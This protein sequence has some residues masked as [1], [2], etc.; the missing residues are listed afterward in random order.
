M[1]KY[2]I[3]I[4]KPLP[5]KQTIQ[6]YQDFDAL[7]DYYKVNTKYEFWK[8]LYRNPLNFAVL[9]LVVAVGALIFDSVA[10]ES[11]R[12]LFLKAP[13]KGLL[14]PSESTKLST[15]EAQEL[16]I[17]ENIKVHL[18]QEAFENQHGE[19]VRGTISFYYRWL[20]KAMNWLKRGL[21]MENNEQ[22]LAS[23][24]ILELFAMQ[25]DQVLHLRKGKNI[26]VI[27]TLA[28]SLIS[29]HPR[30]L[31]TLKRDWI[32]LTDTS[33][34]TIWDSSALAQLEKPVYLAPDADINELVAKGSANPKLQ[35]P[36]QPFGVK[37]S[38]AADY[39]HF[40]PYDKVYWEYQD[41]PGST[42]PWEEQLLGPENG[43]ND[44]R[45]RRIGQNQYQ[46]TFTKISSQNQMIRKKVIAVPLFEAKSKAEA[47]R[48]YQAKLAA[49]ERAIQELEAQKQQ[50]ITQAQS[51]YKD[52]LEVYQQAFQNSLKFTH[53]ECTVALTELGFV[54]L[55]KPLKLEAES[56]QK[57]PKASRQWWMGTDQET[58]LEMSKPGFSGKIPA[59]LHGDV[60]SLI[61]GE[62]QIN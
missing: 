38:N 62:L 22:A 60:V 28:D 1:S 41:V 31:D 48:I 53:H 8:N 13:S 26:Q 46:L 3:H 29:Y 55:M 43:W 27:F 54:G 51:A 44:V 36:N 11:Y 33:W 45:V 2:K 30:Q 34:N 20:P 37:V 15:N 57:D 61:E 50:V 17:A 39:P 18:P 49:Y 24:G 42:N 40:S 56:P 5:D 19:A 14:P 35:K 52:S 16:Q 6:A 10:E 9:V 59:D 7:Y 58:L 32:N 23:K 47:Q 25:G 21:P 4:D 12:S